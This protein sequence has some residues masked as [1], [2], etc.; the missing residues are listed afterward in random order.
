MKWIIKTGSDFLKDELVS[1]NELFEF[2][3]E[4]EL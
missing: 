1:I 3:E 2:I 4:D